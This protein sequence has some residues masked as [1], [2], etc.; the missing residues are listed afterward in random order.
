MNNADTS[1]A[2]TLH[3]PSSCTCGRMIWLSTHCDFFALNLGTSDREAHIEAALGP[4]SSSV[5]FHPEQL[6]EVV[7]D[8]FW[9]MWHVWEPAEGMKV[10]RQTGAAQ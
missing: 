7:A 2:V 8:L 10:T 1:T 3:N 6:K 9:Q 4:A 5:Q